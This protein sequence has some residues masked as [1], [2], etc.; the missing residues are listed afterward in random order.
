M[1]L[2]AHAPREHAPAHAD[3]RAA[4]LDGVGDEVAACLREPHRVGVDERAAT[5]RLDRQ[6]GAE[7]A[8]ERPPGLRGV[9]EQ[10]ADVDQRGALPRATA[11]AG[12]GEIVERERGAAELEIDRRRSLLALERVQ[13][14][15]RGAQ[16]SA[17]LVP[18]V[19]D[20]RRVADKPRLQHRR[21]RAAQ[22][23]RAPAE[24]GEAAHAATV[25]PRKPRPVAAR[26]GR[27]CHAGHAATASTGPST[28]R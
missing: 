12:G 3:R 6:L 2:D 21:E 13:A 7:G 27:E 16:R 20:Q 22:R 1:D 28:R 26:H 9:V 8:G 17:E 15:P 25:E 18:R 4:V 10:G 5:Q 11:V 24:E 14:E 19:R 23:S